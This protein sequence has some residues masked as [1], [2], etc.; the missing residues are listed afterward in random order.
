MGV[1][2]F[3]LADDVDDLLEAGLRDPGQQGPEGAHLLLK[4]FHLNSNSVRAYTLT[5]R[6]GVKEL[7]FA[8]DMSGNLEPPPPGHFIR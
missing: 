1:L 3:D 6:D 8:E 2:E 7:L 4:Q 5:L